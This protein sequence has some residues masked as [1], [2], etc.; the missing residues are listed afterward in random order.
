[1]KAFIQISMRYGR[2]TRFTCRPQV[3]AQNGSG[4][5]GSAQNRRRLRRSCTLTGAPLSNN[6]YGL[7]NVVK[8]L[9]LARAV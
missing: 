4:Q 6:L 3:A 7:G 1:M 2:I 8:E 9:Q 5:N